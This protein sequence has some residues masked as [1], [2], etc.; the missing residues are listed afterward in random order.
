MGGLFGGGGGAAQPVDNSATQ[1]VLF[2]HNPDHPRFVKLS[3]LTWQAQ[4]K[5]L[6]EDPASF[7]IMKQQLINSCNHK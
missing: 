1:T 5:L 6:E 3:E 7:L 2:L 4:D